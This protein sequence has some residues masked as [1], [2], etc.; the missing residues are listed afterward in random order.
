MVLEGSCGCH[1]EKDLG[2]NKEKVGIAHLTRVTR[3]VMMRRVRS[4]VLALV[5]RQTVNSVKINVFIFVFKIENNYKFI[6]FIINMC[7]ICRKENLEGLIRINLEGCQKVKELPPLPASLRRLYCGGTQLSVLPP[8]P[9]SLHTLCC[10][11]TQITALPSL[12]ASLQFLDCS[13]TRITSLPPLP[14]SL[15]YLY[16]SNTQLSVLPSLPASL[17]FLDCS[18]TRITSLP[19]LPASLQYLYCSNTWILTLH[20]VGRLQPPPN[21]NVFSVDNPF[22]NYKNPDYIS[23][24]EK[25]IRIQKWLALQCFKRRLNRVHILKKYVPKVIINMILK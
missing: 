22:L 7:L 8:L 24:V 6:T 12:P 19:P 23:N 15:Q 21:C 1:G 25:L 11:N 4:L 13:H 2:S 14:D 3:N 18:H 20:F 9:A 17:Q 10:S 5:K 16:C